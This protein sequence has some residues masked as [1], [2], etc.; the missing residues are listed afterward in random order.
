[1]LARGGRKWVARVT[2]ASEEDDRGPRKR[3]NDDPFPIDI[4]E[5][6]TSL[7]STL[8]RLFYPFFT[9]FPVIIDT[10]LRQRYRRVV[11]PLCFPR[12]K[13]AFEGKRRFWYSR[14]IKL[15]CRLCRLCETMKFVLDDSRRVQ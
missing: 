9:I 10:I 15:E 14:V 4:M 7:A 6:T 11:A 1:M 3:K 2:E 13:E 8:F 5:T 12:R